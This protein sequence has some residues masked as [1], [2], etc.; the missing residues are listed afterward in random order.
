MYVSHSVCNNE[1]IFFSLVEVIS[2]TLNFSASL[3]EKRYQQ[4]HIE[5]LTVKPEILGIIRIII[6]GIMI[7]DDKPAKY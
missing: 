6:K 3:F 2:L 7:R 5:L 1:I 4:I